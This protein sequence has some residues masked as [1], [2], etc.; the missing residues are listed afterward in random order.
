MVAWL[1][2]A[3][4]DEEQFPHPDDFDI[5]RTPN[6]HVAFGYGVHFCLGAPL[7]RLEAR[8]TLNILLARWS[9]IRRQRKIPL[10]PLGSYILLGLRHLPVTFRVRKGS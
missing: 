1:A 6:R 10:E 8:V 7:A 3:N 5:H 2:S 9:D 4:R